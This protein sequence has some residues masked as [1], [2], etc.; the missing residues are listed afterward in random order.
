VF[1]DIVN[2]RVFYSHVSALE[3]ANDGDPATTAFVY[4]LT[5]LRSGVPTTLLDLV[6]AATGTPGL[7]RTDLRLATDLA[8][9]LYITTKQDGWLR[10]LVPA[11]VGAIP[12]LS[13]WM[14]L[15]MVALIGTI[16]SLAARRR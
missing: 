1:G 14:T 9:N 2:G 15:G 10:R 16:G 6:R 13:R 11:P 4:E 5:L 8:G 12:A 3:G 7:A